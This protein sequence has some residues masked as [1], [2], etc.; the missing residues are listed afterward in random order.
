[1]TLIRRGQPTALAL[2]L[3]A[4]ACTTSP[5]V[6]GNA[7]E[8][9]PQELARRRAPSAAERADRIRRQE[10]AAARA[11]PREET[12]PVDQPRI[13]VAATRVFHR[14]DCKLLAGVATVEQLR[15][16][17]PWEAVDARYAPCPECRPFQ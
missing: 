7:P 13:G 6:V 3:A 12:P 11:E 4:G 1:M 16:T 8:T 2:L 9:E 17:S 10:E 14:P 5:R 15:F